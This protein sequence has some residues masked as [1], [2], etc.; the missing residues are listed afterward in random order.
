MWCWLEGFININNFFFFAAPS[1]ASCLV[2]AASSGSGAAAARNFTWP[3]RRLG[4]LV[5]W[6]GQSLR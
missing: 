2:A 3:T 4:R 5:A 6:N 1:R